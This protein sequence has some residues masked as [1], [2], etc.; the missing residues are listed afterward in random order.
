MDKLKNHIIFLKNF[1]K[2]NNSKFGGVGISRMSMNY[3][4]LHDFDEHY[5]RPETSAERNER[6]RRAQIRQQ[7]ISDRNI[8]ILE[9]NDRMERIEQAY[10][11]LHNLK[12]R[13]YRIPNKNLCRSI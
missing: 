6:M 1:L 9:Y 3:P 10:N 2:N 11:M 7:A 12:G 8:A 5:Y 13:K 4:I